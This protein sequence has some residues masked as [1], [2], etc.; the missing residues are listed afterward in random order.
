MSLASH[1]GACPGCAERTAGTSP[2]TA[3]GVQAAGAGCQCPAAASGLRLLSQC[4]EQCAQ[5]S[6]DGLEILDRCPAEEV[7]GRVL[8]DR[9]AELTIMS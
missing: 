1:L 9:G 7:I 6:A 4:L 5:L 8:G 3:L 2:S